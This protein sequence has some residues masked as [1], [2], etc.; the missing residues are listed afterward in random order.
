I[1]RLFRATPQRE[2]D[3][4]PLRSEANQQRWQGILETT[5]QALE[6][7]EQARNACTRSS[8]RALCVRRGHVDATAS[9]SPHRPPGAARLVSALTG[10]DLLSVTPLPRRNLGASGYDVSL[11]ALGSWRT[12]ERI[13]RE[14]GMAVMRAAREAGITFLDDARYDD[15]TGEAPIPTGWSE[16]VFGALF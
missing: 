16:I 6:R 9:L 11:M 2:P 12:F 13:P 8:I 5:G 4:R 3:P 7:Y 10:V 14:Q 15:E 1:A